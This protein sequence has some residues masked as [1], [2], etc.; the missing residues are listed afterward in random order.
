MQSHM[1][2][3]CHEQFGLE[4]LSSIF[5]VERAYRIPSKHNHNIT[6]RQRK[7]LKELANMEDIIV[8]QT[9]KWGMTVILDHGLYMLYIKML[10]D[11]QTYKKCG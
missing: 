3:K 8:R 11:S 4:A 5:K 7:S 9:D 10:S 2:I 1:F 6:L